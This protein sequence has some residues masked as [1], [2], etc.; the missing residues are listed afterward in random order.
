M[1]YTKGPWRVGFSDGSGPEYINTAADQPHKA[2]AKVR[3]GCSCCE[4]TSPLTD[5]EKANAALLAAAP[6]MY[7]ALKA[8]E[9]YQGLSSKTRKLVDQALK[10]AKGV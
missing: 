10:D 9:S 7:E 6:R 8:V 4:I 5:E 2:I 3:W 1:K